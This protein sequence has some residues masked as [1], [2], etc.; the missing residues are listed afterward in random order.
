MLTL[1]QIVNQL[2]SIQENHAQ[3][4]DFRFGNP[5]DYGSEED[6][7]Y[8]L[9]GAWLEP[10][11][12]AK[13]KSTTKLKVYVVGLVNIGESDELPNIGMRNDVLSD[14]QLIL[15]DVFAQLWEYFDEASIVLAPDAAFEHIE[16]AWD[17]NVYGW[18]MTIDINQFFARDTCQVPT[19]ETP[20]PPVTPYLST[21]VYI[22][23]DGAII[24][25]D[26]L[27]ESDLFYFIAE[28][29]NVSSG[30]IRVFWSDPIELW[31]GSTWLDASNELSLPFTNSR[32]ITEKI[33]KVR[34][35][36]YSA[37]NTLEAS[38]PGLQLTLTQIIAAN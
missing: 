13:G 16:G 35:A 31:N 2:Q 36:S 4:S 21:N 34:L 37:I 10:G 3:L 18:S 27:Q 8:F 1:N 24:S 30:N 12:L 5:A 38:S 22:E 15:M 11:T 19:R 17:D 23:S 25:L 29:L 14:T 32:F 28:G 9:L 33:Y 26:V 6:I 7:K 20:A